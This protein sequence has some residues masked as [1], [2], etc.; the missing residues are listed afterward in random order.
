[1]KLAWERRVALSPGN[2]GRATCI[3]VRGLRRHVPVRGGDR[4]LDRRHRPSR[5]RSGGSIPA[6]G[7]VLWATG[8]PNGVL[9]AP[10]LDG[11]G[12]LAVGTYGS[13]TTPNA[14]Y[15]INAS[16]GQILRTLIS[17][18]P[19]FAQSVFADG[20]LFTANGNGVYAWGS[21]SWRRGQRSGDQQCPHGAAGLQV[22][23]RGRR[24]FERQSR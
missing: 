15:L 3:A 4:D 11:A 18:Q 17:R 6:T 19:D 9:G 7:K 12:V 5:D 22:I 10:T 24:G 20:M 14:V 21:S 2:T 23:E 8:L 1:M 13:G 16:T